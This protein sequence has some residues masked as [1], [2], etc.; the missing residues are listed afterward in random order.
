MRRL[1]GSARVATRYLAL[2][3]ERYAQLDGFTAANDAFLDVA[4]DL[5]AQ[6]VS[7]LADAGLRPPTST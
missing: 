3:I 7:A 6:A 2:P 1:H 5:G 4:V